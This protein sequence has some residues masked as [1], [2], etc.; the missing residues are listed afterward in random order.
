MSALRLSNEYSFQ[1]IFKAYMSCRQRKRNS[2]SAMA[3]ETRFERRLDDLLNELNS[4]SYKIGRSE[5][6]VV[7]K[8]KPREIWAAQF[9][10]RVVHHLVY[11]DVGEWF[12]SR[13]IEDTFSCIKG[14]GTL[15]G[16][17]RLMDFH[18]RATNNYSSDCWYL[19]FDIANYFVSIDKNILWRMVESKIGS[20]SLT[21]RLIKQI[22]FYDPTE[23]AI[24]KKG[25]DFSIVPFHKSLWNSDKSKGLPIGNLTSQFL[26]NVYLDPLDKFIKHKLKQRYYARYVDDA[27][28]ISNSKDDLEACLK[29]ISDFMEN[30]L[31]LKLHPDKCFIRKASQGINFVGYI[32]KPYR[33]YSRRST[34]DAAKKSSRNIG[35]ESISSVNSYLGI[36]KHSASYNIR[37]EICNTASIP[38]L[39]APSSDYGKIVKL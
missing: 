31:L 10:D 30:E 16:S 20:E 27:V 13:F 29:N 15:A 11:N 2:S 6:F 9:K 17:N 35:I 32:V 8:P 4:G 39:I 3:Y 1:D 25:S 36:I 14:R 22:I 26:S 12:E 37:K 28:I 5:V 18:R 21:S 19:Q 24:I 23:N 34:I 38:S 7:D 33:R